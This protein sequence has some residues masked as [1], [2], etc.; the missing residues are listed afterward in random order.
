MPSCY[1][2]ASELPPVVGRGR[3]RKYCTDCRPPIVGYL[4][5]NHSDRKC[6]SCG[7]GFKPKTTA[8]RFCS[9]RCR[10]RVRDLRGPVCTGCGCQMWKSR[11]VADEPMCLSCR[12][13]RATY[14]SASPKPAERWTCTICG[15]QCERPATKGHRPKYCR[16]CRKSDWITPTRRLELYERDAWT[17]WLCEEPVDRTLIGTR[18]QW[19]P[20]L[21]HVIPRAFGGSSNDDNLKLAHWWCNAVRGDGRHAPEVFRVS[22]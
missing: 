11:D 4:P 22:A 15:I 3:P 16:D 12:R 20:S 14:R 21:D 13:A 10:Y 19:R 17:C 18:D 5:V 2:C 9:S 1:E 8:S 6:A 7:A